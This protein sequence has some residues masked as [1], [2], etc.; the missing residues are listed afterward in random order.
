[1]LYGYNSIINNWL[2][3]LDDYLVSESS[4]DYQIST[5]YLPHGVPVAAICSLMI[6]HAVRFGS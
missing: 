1:M 6:A 3:Y 5:L 2:L 4:Q